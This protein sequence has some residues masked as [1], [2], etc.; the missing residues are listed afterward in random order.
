MQTSIF[1]Q[2]TEN[3]QRE[4]S[5][6]IEGIFYTERTVLLKGIFSWIQSRKVILLNH[7]NN[8]IE[9]SNQLLEY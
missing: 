1:V 2:A 7:Q 3:Y 8:Y 4:L 9:C 6:I 5:A